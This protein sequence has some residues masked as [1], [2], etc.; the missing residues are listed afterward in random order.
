MKLSDYV[1]PEEL[2]AL[3]QGLVLFIVALTIFALFGFIVVPGLRNANK[4]SL[5][6]TADSTL[7][8]PG[9]L[10]PTKFLARMGK[11]ISPLDP[12]AVLTPEPGLLERGKALYAKNCEQCHGPEGKGNGPAGAGLNPPPRNLTSPDGWKLGYDRPGIFRVLTEGIK[13]SSMAAYD[14]LSPTNRMA[15][16]HHV[17]S[18]GKFQRAPEKPEAL[19]ALSQQ[20][21]RPGG[22]EP[23]TVPVSFAIRKMASEFTSPGTIELPRTAEGA[24]PEAFRRAVAD[25]GRVALTLS[26]SSAW[27]TSTE[28]LAHLAVA[29]A[30][31][32]GFSTRATE[33]GAEGWRALQSELI[34]RLGR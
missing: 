29:G 6:S 16:V 4:P 32:N 1:S 22:K 11:E 21:A 28:I 7:G 2:R 19:E 24:G 10:D 3:L 8:D 12:K 27:V 34:K 18:L 9:W 30:P 14:Y 23:N 26:K 15:L 5:P 13:G 33:L 20:L 25:P 17:Q 31:S